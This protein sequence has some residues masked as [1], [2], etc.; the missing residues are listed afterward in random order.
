[1]A[2]IIGLWYFYQLSESVLLHL[3]VQVIYVIR[4]PKDTAV[5][6]FHY[7]QQ[8]P[9]LPKVDKW[10][11]FLDMFLKGEGTHSAAKKTSNAS[12]RSR[13]TESTIV[14][15]FDVGVGRLGSG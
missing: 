9:H 8:N 6:M 5:S 2:I 1:M 12:V 11:T 14:R 3:S 13:L 15:Q 4:N 7:Y 10:A